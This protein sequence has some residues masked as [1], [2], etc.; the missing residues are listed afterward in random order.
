ML[1][2]SRLAFCKNWG[3]KVGI[4]DIRGGVYNPHGIDIHQALHYSKEHGN[5]AGLPN[6]EAVSNWELLTLPCDI[7]IPAAVENQLTRHNATHVKAR[8]IIEAA[9]RQRQT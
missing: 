2:V 7:L 3:A 8:L 9:P 1:A 6:T 5:L 4:S